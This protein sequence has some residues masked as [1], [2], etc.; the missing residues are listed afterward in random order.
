MK[1]KPAQRGAVNLLLI[2]G[3]IVV[4]IVILIAT[5][6]LK[7]SGYIKYTP[8]NKQSSS[9][10][11]SENPKP[12]PKPSQVELSETYSDTNLGFSIKYPTNWGLDQTKTPTLYTK[13]DGSTS[14]AGS[15]AGVVLTSGPLG[16]MKEAQFATI[17]DL[18][19]VQIK[20]QFVGATLGEEKDLKIDNLDAHYYE[21]EITQ[22]GQEYK[23][24]FYI[25]VDENKFY[26]LVPASKKAIWDKYLPTFEAIVNSFKPL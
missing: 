21:Y 24:R 6:T 11:S 19:R 9:D 26:A 20:K 13:T 25:I 16:E 8:S 5:G 4:V 12:T 17:V 1:N 10:T 23:S 14:S 3:V 18:N 7:F 2:A 22:N 15:E